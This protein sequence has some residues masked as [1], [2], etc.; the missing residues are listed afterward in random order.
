MR[1]GLHSRNGHLR[2]PTDIMMLLRPLRHLARFA[3]A[4]LTLLACG[5]GAGMGSYPAAY[6]WGSSAPA[7]PATYAFASEQKNIFLRLGS[8]ESL[9][10]EQGVPIEPGRRYTLGVDLRSRAPKAALKIGRAHV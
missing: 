1:C 2:P 5:L 8:G 9:Y 4:C 7:R 6:L 3:T 10:F